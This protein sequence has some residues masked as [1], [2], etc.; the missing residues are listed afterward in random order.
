MGESATDFFRYIREI[1]EQL[2]SSEL[3]VQIFTDNDRPENLQEYTELYDELNSYINNF[4]YE[5]ITQQPYGSTNTLL[6]EAIAFFQSKGINGQMIDKLVLPE[7]QYYGWEHSI[8][9]LS[10]GKNNTQS[11]ILKNFGCSLDYDRG[12]I[13]NQRRGASL[14]LKI[15]HYN[16]IFPDEKISGGKRKSKRRKLKKYKKLT[17]RTK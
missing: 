12:H 7:D 3:P 13:T 11:E 2:E 17:M 15:D 4:F 6:S 1:I 10:L 8:L 5:C 9:Y 14:K 16:R